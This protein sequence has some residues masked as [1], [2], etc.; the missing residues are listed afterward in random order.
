MIFFEIRKIIVKLIFFKIW[1]FLFFFNVLFWNVCELYASLNDFKI[2]KICFSTCFEVSNFKIF[3]FWVNYMKSKNLH[4][5]KKMVKNEKNA[6]FL[7]FSK[8]DFTAGKQTNSADFVAKCFEMKFTCPNFFF[9]SFGQKFII[10]SQ[11]SWTSSKIW[12]KMVKKVNF[13]KFQW[14][15]FWPETDKFGRFLADRVR[16]K[17][18]FSQFFFC[19]NETKIRDFKSKKHTPPQKKKSPIFL[20]GV[21]KFFVSLI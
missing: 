16:N 13:S 18:Y 3:I 8:V 17:V 2:F 5:H 9:I 21:S 20:G 6:G 1:I 14:P 10:L 4:F 19:F 15:I 12:S 7:K 11:K